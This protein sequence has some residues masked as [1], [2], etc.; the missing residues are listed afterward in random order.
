ML[1]QPVQRQRGEAHGVEQNRDL[2][3]P[4]RLQGL[5]FSLRNLPVL[6]VPLPCLC[7]LPPA[8]CPAPRLCSLVFSISFASRCE[9]LDHLTHLGLLRELNG[10]RHILSA[11][12]PNTPACRTLSHLEGGTG[13]GMEKERSPKITEMSFTSVMEKVFHAFW[14]LHSAKGFLGIW[15]IFSTIF[16]PDSLQLLEKLFQC[17]DI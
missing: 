1:L 2:K 4:L 8:S 14:A 13:S 15:Q 9:T 11:T 10:R 7:P 5:N 17:K 3:S 16:S 12:I 6:P